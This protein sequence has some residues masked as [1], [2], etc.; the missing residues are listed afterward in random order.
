MRAAIAERYAPA[1]VNK[2]LAAL[3]RVL[4]EAW[5]L[6]H[7]NAE[8]YARARDLPT[9]ETLPAGRT[10]STGELAAILSACAT[11]RCPACVRDAALIVALYSTLMR[12]SEVVA[13]MVEDYDT[14]E[15]TL[16]CDAAKGARRG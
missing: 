14:E 13:F 7:L 9:S 5:R 11:D 8:D 1:T 15:G 6:G 12:R 4:Q 16:R 10:L 3:R 2:M